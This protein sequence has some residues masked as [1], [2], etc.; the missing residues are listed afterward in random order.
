MP[1]KDN[2]LL[3]AIKRQM[4]QNQAEHPEVYAA[5][6]E[7]LETQRRLSQEAATL[8]KAKKDY[9]GKLPEFLD[10]FF[11]AIGVEQQLAEIKEKIFKSR[12]TISRLQGSADYGYWG[13]SWE[14]GALLGGGTVSPLLHQ[15][16]F[17]A[18]FQY[19]YFG[20]ILMTITNS[21]LNKEEVRKRP[22]LFVGFFG[23]TEQ[24]V[25]DSFRVVA[26]VD[27]PIY[28]YMQTPEAYTYWQRVAQDKSHSI[29]LS[30]RFQGQL[31]YFRRF[32]DVI[33]EPGFQAQAKD[34]THQGIL[35]M[36]QKYSF[37]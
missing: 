32:Q 30:G 34:V 3:D 28:T 10:G 12:G 31:D 8:D 2:P 9:T 20:E 35:A 15:K 21:T 11:G 36:F 6:L 24:P 37:L 23:P 16:V 4:A 25:F 33:A 5:E 13:P 22:E 19:S 29:D 26:A 27:Q 1:D 17:I 7:R 18:G 14:R